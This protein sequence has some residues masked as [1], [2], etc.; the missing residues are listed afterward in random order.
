M[1]SEFFTI[2]P[3]GLVSMRE[4]TP[5]DVL[6]IPK[7]PVKT[8]LRLPLLSI[9]HFR[10]ETYH[11]ILFLHRLGD[12]NPVLRVPVFIQHFIDDKLDTVA[13]DVNA[14]VVFGDSVVTNYFAQVTSWEQ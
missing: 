4:S 10:N 12:F 6:I 8:I 3:N 7:L 14:P 13:S 1:S 11:A 9:A 5:G 2:H